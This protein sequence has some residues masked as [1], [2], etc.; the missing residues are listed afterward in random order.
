ME[1]HNKE[2]DLASVTIVVG[3]QQVI[4]LTGLSRTTIWRL[5]RAGK[6]PERL[7]LSAHRVGWYQAEVAEW[8]ASRPRG[9]AG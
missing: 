5:E 4:R 6:F 2:N 9:M 1:E 8:I 3:T 7:R